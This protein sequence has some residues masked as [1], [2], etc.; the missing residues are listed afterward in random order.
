MFIVRHN[1]RPEVVNADKDTEQAYYPP[2]GPVGVPL[3]VLQCWISYSSVRLHRTAYHLG[4]DT[5]FEIRD[6]KLT[7]RLHSTY[8][9][10][11]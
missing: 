7:L 10:L 8:S 5:D 2:K 11:A 9:T 4:K 6:T 3:N 1:P